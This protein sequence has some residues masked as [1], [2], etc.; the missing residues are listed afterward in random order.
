MRCEKFE[1]RW[2]SYLDDRLSPRTDAGLRRH[3]ERCGACRALWD[4]FEAIETGLELAEIPE[5]SAGFAARVAALAALPAGPAAA[6]GPLASENAA[7][8]VAK[9]EPVVA[10]RAND[11]RGSSERWRLSLALGLAV[12]FLAVGIAAW[13][14]G[15]PAQNE[16]DGQAPLAANDA[17]PRPDA[18]A[19]AAAETPVHANGPRTVFVVGDN[20]RMIQVDA[21]EVMQ[22][23]GVMSTSWPRVGAALV[24]PELAAAEP[25][26]EWVGHVAGQLR[27][28]TT[29]VTGT[30]R[31]LRSSFSMRGNHSPAPESKPQALRWEEP[32]EGVWV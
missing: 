5:L 12:A 21:E 13:Q 9:I 16:A 22:R 14:W 25:D 30:L 31:V 6:N 24:D 27:P 15:A 28:L 32:R 18:A 2:N 7:P 10:A 17:P 8:A 26:A 3:A 19:G 4:G 11:R 1:D 29:P 20:G 23:I